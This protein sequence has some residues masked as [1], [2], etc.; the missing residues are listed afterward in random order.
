[1]MYSMT[2]FASATADAHGRHLVWELKSVNH[3][4]LET[5]FRI[6]DAIRSIEHPLR[7]IARKHLKRGKLDCTL[8][9]EKLAGSGGISIN[10]EVLL[11]L[12]AGLEQVRRDAPEIGGI[13]PMELLRWPGVMDD[14][15]TDDPNLKE[16]AAE[17]FEQALTELINSRSREGQALHSTIDA[18]LVEIGGIVQGLKPLT[19]GLAEQQKIKLQQRLADLVAN[20]D[21]GRLEQEVAMLA[22]KVDVAEELDRLAIHV[23]EARSHINGQGPHGRRLDFLTQELN[24]EANTLGAKSILPETSQK[25]V[26]L[27]VIIEQIR[28]QVQNIE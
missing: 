1:M 25:A 21:P 9:L 12:M 15:P 13:S 18:R 14:T 6:P 17:L 7:E 5:N 22:Q 24:R 3:R 23:E 10:R 19:Q 4:F 2:A 26:D 27:K 28:E 11:Q 20:V 16:S 8:K